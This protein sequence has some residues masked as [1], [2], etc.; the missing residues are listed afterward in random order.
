[1]KDSINTAPFGYDGQLHSTWGSSEPEGTLS[2][3]EDLGGHRKS[4]PSGET[5]AE[6]VR[7]IRFERMITGLSTHFIDL[8][9]ELVDAGIQVALRKIGEFA[10]VDRAY[11]FRFSPS[12]TTMSNTHEWCAAG[13]SPEIE[14][15][16]GL[17]VE[18]FPWWCERI[19]RQQVIH[20]PC[21]ESLGDEAAAERAILLEQSIRSVVVVP[22]TYARKVEGFLGFDSVS[23]QKHWNEED[24]AL[25][26]IVGE[27]FMNAIERQKAEALRRSLESQLIASR[28]MENVARLAGGVAH[29]FNNLLGVMLNCATV[30]S[31]GVV[32]TGLETYA[33][34]L[35]TASKQAADLT[36][37]LL[38]IGRRGVMEELT[39][40]PNRVL[41]ELEHLVRRTLGEHIEFQLRLDESIGCVKIGRSHF[42]QMIVNLAMN[43]RDAMLEG[44]LFR[45]TTE[46]CHID[47]AAAAKRIDVTEGRYVLVR[48]TDTGCGMTPDVAARA[49][50]PFFTTKRPTGTGLGLSTLHSI[51]AENGGYVALD[52]EVGKGTTV[53]IFMPFVE[54][55]E[56]YLPREREPLGPIPRGRGEVILVV[57]DCDNLRRVLCDSLREWG[58]RVFEAGNAFDGSKLCEK[59]GG[60]IQLLLTDIVMPGMS[61]CQLAERAKREF[62]IRRI[63]YM[64]GY[65]DEVL[66]KRGAIEP[67]VQLFQKPFLV[68]SLLRYLRQTF[69]AS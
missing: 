21:V 30:I 15:L 3:L 13:I 7:R 16:Q 6:L 49:F 58:Y 50:D 29:D 8:G 64:S 33:N 17:P 52:S 66:A 68:D 26:K 65:E 69:D 2:C 48:A 9:V 40:H 19:K 53:E 41:R 46:I 44:G 56:T 62:G 32:N 43:A 45:I 12:G 27:M 28:S 35:L 34:D 23:A 25:L 59:H 18:V 37:Q 1:M 31:R 11:I 24:I 5:E 4:S 61:G 36:R 60:E 57:E 14:H 47:A 67:N 10:G 63:A 54:G 55:P 51:V 20:V 39:L 42:D 22:L 38:I